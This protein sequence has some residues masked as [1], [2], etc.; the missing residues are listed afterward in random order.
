MIFGWVAE[1]FGRSVFSDWRTKGFR[2]CPRI[3]EVEGEQFKKR[4]MPGT[5]TIAKLA[6]AAFERA[7]RQPNKIGR[8]AAR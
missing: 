8:G 5:D 4:P 7:R 6:G 2:G 3:R 1:R